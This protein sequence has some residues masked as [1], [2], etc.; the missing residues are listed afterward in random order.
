MLI[1]ENSIECLISRP[2]QHAMHVYLIH[3]ARLL[4][5]PHVKLRS[6][7]YT[8]FGLFFNGITLYDF[9]SKYCYTMSYNLLP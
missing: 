7:C 5:D 2:M 6:Q 4:N 9:S 3:N 1:D 8:E